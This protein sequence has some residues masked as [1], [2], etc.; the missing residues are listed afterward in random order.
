MKS[1]EFNFM[2]LREFKWL[3]RSTDSLDF[4][5]A[6]SAVG[7][8]IAAIIFSGLDWTDDVKLSQHLFLASA[9]L[10][11]LAK[12]FWPERPRWITTLLVKSLVCISF[13]M[14]FSNGMS[15]MSELQ[16]FYML[17]SVGA[18]ASLLRT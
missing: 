8:G 16:I 4:F 9:G 17:Y 11:S 12:L 10:L 7:F 2:R 13:V 6:M 18:F 14:V 3:L 1:C 5:L 15:G